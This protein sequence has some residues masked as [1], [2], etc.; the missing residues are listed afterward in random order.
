MP[1]LVTSS[2]HVGDP[3]GNFISGETSVTTMT[4][5]FVGSGV[6]HLHVMN[7]DVVMVQK[8]TG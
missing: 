5:S 3:T 1:V 4:S 8:G 7:A 6:V 2:C